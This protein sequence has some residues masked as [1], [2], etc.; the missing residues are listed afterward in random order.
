VPLRDLTFAPRTLAGPAALALAA[1]AMLGCG[2]GPAPVKASPDRAGTFP[3]PPRTSSATVWAVGDGADGSRG[4]RTVA[5]LIARGRPARLLYLGDVYETGSAADFRDH[6]DPVYGALRGRTLPTPGNHEW[7]GRPEGYDRYWASV[8]G[9]RPPSFYAVRVAGW[10]ILSLNSEEPLGRGSR[11]GRWLER[12][13][14]T[15]GT[16]RMAFWHRPRFSAGLHGDQPDVEPL[17]SAVRGRAALVLN[18]HDHDMQ[19]MRARS[20]ITALIAGAG[21]HGRYPVARGD[22]RLVWSNASTYG[23]LKLRLAPGRAGFAFVSA[24]GT[25]L[26][27]GSASCKRG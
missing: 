8:T 15:P 23:A 4:A 24:D 27:R 17:W 22:P 14:A 2:A 20:G 11:Q 6:Y 12:Q 10:T 9:R 5:R 13:L 18:G 1:V 7:P 26:H 25:V 19:Q 16:C 21:G 3:T